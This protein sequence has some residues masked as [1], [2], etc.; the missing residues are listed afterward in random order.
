MIRKAMRI[1]LVALVAAFALSSAAEAAPKKA[2][3]ARAKHSSRVTAG[4]Q[5]K[6]TTTRK[7]TVKRKRVAPAGTKKAAKRARSTKPR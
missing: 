1:L 3:R 4:S 6:S 5:T 7:K 2:T